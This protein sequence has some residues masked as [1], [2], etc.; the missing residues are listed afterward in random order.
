MAL[1]ELEHGSLVMCADSE[2]NDNAT[3]QQCSANTLP[4]QREHG[5]T[6]S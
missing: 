2:R 3:D 5:C 6:H 1:S 4:Y